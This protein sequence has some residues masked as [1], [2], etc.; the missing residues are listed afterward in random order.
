MPILF[1]IKKLISQFLYPLPAALILMTLG[2][3]LLLFTKRQKLGKALNLIGLCLLLI[4]SYKPTA[5]KFL[6]HLERQSLP[7]YTAVPATVPANLPEATWILVLSSG[8]T[9]DTSL[10]ATSQLSLQSLARLVEGIRLHRLLPNSKLLLSGGIV[11]NGRSNGEVMAVAAQELG[12]SKEAIVVG[13]LALDTPQEAAQL[14]NILGDAP[15]VLVTSALHMQRSAALFTK[16]GMQPVPSPA[17]YVTKDVDQDDETPPAPGN[18][19]PQA[20]MLDAST[21]GVHEYL[22]TLWAKLRGLL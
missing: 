6:Y 4:F 22:G 19:F 21:R 20:H 9:I 2:L 15:F 10:P 12:V 8:H 1:V 7:L 18:F 16:L 13:P 14:H 11:M 5:L 3:L 17:A